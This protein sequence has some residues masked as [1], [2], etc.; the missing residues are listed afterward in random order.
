MTRWPEVP[1]IEAARL[2]RGTE[3][4]SANYTDVSRGVRFL[5]VGDIT[6]KTDNPVFTEPSQVVMVSD[7]DLLLTL[8]GSPGHVSTGHEGAISSGIRKVE[9]LDPNRVS[10]PWLK[11]S[12]MSSPVQETIRRNTTG[13][14]ILHAASAVPHIRIPVPPPSEQERIVRILDEAEA[15][16]RLRIDADERTNRI[17]AALFDEMF[18]NPSSNLK[19][20]DTATLGGLGTVVTGNTP[21]RSDSS[22]YGNFIEWV[23][24]DNID[25]ARDMVRPSAERLSDTGA[26]R[27]RVVPEGSVLITCIAGSI[28][29]I[30][31]AA[32]TDRKVAINQQINAIVPS[33][34]IESA[35][36]GSLVRSLKPLIQASATGVM[37]RI[38]NKSELE[39]IPA[40]IPP[41]PLQRQFATRV[42][43]IR[44][45]ETAQAVSRKRI[46]ELFQS[47]LHRAFQGTL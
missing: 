19:G 34:N 40:I 27:G 37:T 24:T 8:D 4:G 42:T 39:K 47:L 38:I 35:F 18:G 41:P 10:L 13:V 16:R 7:S 17:T 30:G 36:L 5:R 15:L 14:T 22:F 32:V 43:E 1:L 20:W 23:K 9:S 28:E 6:G 31:D 12:L 26:M 44:E 21:P 11:Y 25:A 3:P 33:E 29:R 46:K 45:L 2:I